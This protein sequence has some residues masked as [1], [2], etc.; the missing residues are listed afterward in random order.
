MTMPPFSRILATTALCLAAVGLSSCTTV[1]DTGSMLD[2]VGKE[3]PSRLLKEEKNKYVTWHQETPMVAWKKGD[4]YYVELPVAYIPAGIQYRD[5]LVC[6]ESLLRR[7]QFFYPEVECSPASIAT[8]QKQK[9]IFY[10]VL[11]AEQ[12]RKAC[13]GYAKWE[14]PPLAGESFPVLPAASVN[15]EGA[16]RLSAEYSR[17]LETSAPILLRRVPVRRTLGNQLRRP[18]TWVLDTADIPLT[19]AASPVGWLVNLIYYP[20]SK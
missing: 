6:N 10:A 18:L 12:F 14:T 11:T 13:T 3:E 9:E 4:T 2:N 1:I 17:S 19:I 8:C 16:E 7:E 15:M 5:Y 20:F